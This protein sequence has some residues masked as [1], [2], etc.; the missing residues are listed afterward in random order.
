MEPQG[1]SFGFP[2][3]RQERKKKGTKNRKDKWKTN[4]QV[5]ELNPAISRITLNGNMLN[6]HLKFKAELNQVR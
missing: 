4:T 5:M 2:R 3:R 6:T 1:K